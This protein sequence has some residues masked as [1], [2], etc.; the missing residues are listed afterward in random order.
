[1]IPSTLGSFGNVRSAYESENGLLQ[2]TLGLVL[3]LISMTLFWLLLP[4]DL[5]TSL[6]RGMENSS[7]NFPPSEIPSPYFASLVT[8]SSF[9]G[10]STSSLA[11]AFQTKR[12]Y[13]HQIQVSFHFS[14][15]TTS[16]CFRRSPCEPASHID[17]PA[18]HRGQGWSR[19]THSCSPLLPPTPSIF[20]RGPCCEPDYG[21]QSSCGVCFGF[22]GLSSSLVKISHFGEQQ[23][24]LV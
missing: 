4:K 16:V 5:S 15:L 1:M 18:R 12:F 19:W 21:I 8:S 20:L 2:T 23:L 6:S 24:T 7:N 11:G 10:P 14:L 9:Q 22:S 17:P 3:N 13:L